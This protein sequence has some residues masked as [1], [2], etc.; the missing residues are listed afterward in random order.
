[1]RK[2]IEEMV[3]EDFTNLNPPSR[4]KG[5]PSWSTLTAERLFSLN[6]EQFK[7]ITDEQYAFFVSQLYVS[8]SVS[9]FSRKAVFDRILEDN[10]LALTPAKVNCLTTFFYVP[11]EDEIKSQLIENLKQF[12]ESEEREKAIK[13]IEDSFKTLSLADTD[14]KVDYIARSAQKKEKLRALVQ[15][16]PKTYLVGHPEWVNFEYVAALLGYERQNLYKRY[17]TTGVFETRKVVQTRYVK[18]QNVLDFLLER[19][20]PRCEFDENGNPIPDK[21][22]K[23]EPF[24]EIPKLYSYQDFEGLTGLSPQVTSRRAKSGYLGYFKFEKSF[25]FSMEDYLESN[26]AILALQD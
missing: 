8:T 18:K 22:I 6:L 26:T 20:V 10:F 11:F 24:T 16:D 2:R 14:K 1:M 9:Q 12:P 3:L 4:P 21:Q 5:K 23:V 19:Y 15:E 25:R 17:V 13:T 7:R